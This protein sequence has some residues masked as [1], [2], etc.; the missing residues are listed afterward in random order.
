MSIW[1]RVSRIF[2]AEANSAVDTLEDPVKISQQILRDLRDN[3]QEAISGTAEIKALAAQHRANEAESRNK[4]SEWEK[5][6]NELLDRAD[7]GMI[8]E[9][10]ANKLAT[11]CLENQGTHEAK[12]NEYM[13]L[14]EREEKAASAMESKVEE[15][16][17]RI[18]ET[19]SKAASISSRAKTAEAEEKVAKT[20]SSVDTDG[21][22]QTLNRMDEKTKA[23]EFRAQAYAE[24]DGAASS[25]EDKVNKILN[26]TSPNAALE[27][28]KAK[29]KAE[30][31]A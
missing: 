1:E 17:R 28:L 4:A 18:T 8:S 26:R 13:A 6:A 16:R 27:A 5:K 24:I 9:D 21:L 12:A 7:K 25:T 10:E 30:K 11:D 29:R 20:L 31:G 14:A 22:M 19:E 2:R 15:I 3:L 23:T